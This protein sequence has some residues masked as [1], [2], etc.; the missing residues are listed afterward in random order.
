MFFA[1]ILCWS[2]FATMP[3]M[4]IA[5]WHAWNLVLIPSVTR[6]L[7]CW[8]WP[9]LTVARLKTNDLFALMSELLHLGHVRWG[10]ALQSK[11]TGLSARRVPFEAIASWERSALHLHFHFS[12]P[13]LPCSSIINSHVFLSQLLCRIYVG[14]CQSTEICLSKFI[15]TYFSKPT[16]M[17]SSET[18]LHSLMFYRSAWIIFEIIPELCFV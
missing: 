18:R 16:R 9:W 7:L 15:L 5:T 6:Y 12:A 17:L 1:L 2:Q 8:S 14:A 11:T 3:C 10:I 13:I 4:L